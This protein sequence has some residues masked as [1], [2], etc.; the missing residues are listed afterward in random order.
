MSFDPFSAVYL[1]SFTAAPGQCSESGASACR[2]LARGMRSAIR[3]FTL[4]SVV[5]R[6]SWHSL[7]V[8][9]LAVSA[10]DGWPLTLV[11]CA[12][13]GVVR[14]DRLV[15]TL[16]AISQLHFSRR[17]RC[18]TCFHR[19]METLVKCSQ[20]PQTG[21]AM[22]GSLSQACSSW[23]CT[24]DYTTGRSLRSSLG[25]FHDESRR[26]GSKRCAPMLPEDAIEFRR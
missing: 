12:V 26:R 3:S 2:D 24:V 1:S 21:T 20:F 17:E 8:S 18:G 23:K 4:G 14:R 13:F 7:L 25:D 11:L 15:G 22:G 5:L 9:S 19:G 10:I 6:S 16:N